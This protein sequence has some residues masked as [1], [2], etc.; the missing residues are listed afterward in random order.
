MFKWL[1]GRR[2]KSADLLVRLQEGGSFMFDGNLNW[3]FT[4]DSNGE[5]GRFWVQKDGKLILE[6]R[7]SNL[8]VVTGPIVLFEGKWWK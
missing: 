1:F 5:L 2:K 3:G 8:N 7:S 4:G 6:T